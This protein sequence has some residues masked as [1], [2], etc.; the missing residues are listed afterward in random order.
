MAAG[1]LT[2]LGEIAEIF[3]GATVSYYSKLPL[4]GE[5]RLLLISGN[6]LD[7][8]GN[9]VESRL[10]PVWKHKHNTKRFIAQTGDVLVLA[11]GNIRA[12]V[13]AEALHSEPLL[14]S[15]NFAIIRPHQPEVSHAYLAELI[16]TPSSRERLGLYLGKGT[17]SIRAADLRRLKVPIPDPQTRKAVAE[18]RDARN[19]AFRATQALAEQQYATATSMIE[20]L[21][22]S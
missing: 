5:D 11:R 19:E 16:N 13:F 9:I 22:W 4:E 7:E 18:I 6:S 20:G 17:P 14:T 10:I 2:P 12:T 8:H 15:A 1:N 3:M 21:L